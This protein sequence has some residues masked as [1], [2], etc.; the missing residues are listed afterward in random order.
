MKKLLVFFAVSICVLTGSPV[1]AIT[2]NK[3]A[4]VAAQETSAASSVTSLVPTVLGLISNV[5]AL[6]A[7][8]KELTAECIP[9]SQEINF[10]N[11]MVKEWAKTGA[12]SADEVEIR[13]GRKRCD[14]ANGGYKNSIEAF[15][16]TD[17]DELI[18]YDYFAGSGNVGMVWENYPKVG[19]ATYCS[20]GS[21]ASMCSEK[22]KVNVSDIYDI[23]NLIDFT[24][25]DYTSAS[26]LKMAANL[27]AKIEKCS[28]SKLS[29]K[30]REMWGEFLT[31][32][33]NSLGEPTNTGNIM[34]SVSSFSSGGLSG[35][36]GSLGSIATSLFSN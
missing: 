3:A 2:I 17:M 18:C 34:Q 35:G 5:Q 6:S 29:A 12:M 21:P 14:T 25:E 19:T 7:K 8:Q 26:E 36:L 20:D 31:N 15:A 11:N 4:P 16:G 23:F 13:L 27:M 22:N 9:S 32:T 28:Y 33:I 10:V 24:E 30:K 1:G